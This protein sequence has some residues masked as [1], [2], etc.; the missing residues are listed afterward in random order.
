MTTIIT[1]PHPLAPLSGD[2][3]TAARQIVFES[4]KAGIP[5]EDIR[6]AY[7]GLSDP[8]KE[9]VRAVDRGETV[10]V[11]RRLRL[12]LLLGPVANVT[13]VIVSV[14]R[15]VV[16]SWVEVE[17]VR[18]A[19]QMEEAI[20]I[21][22]AL[23]ENPDWNA[24]LDRRGITDRSLVQIDPWPAGTFGTEHEQGRRIT[25]C[26][27][28]LRH[29]PDDNG[30]ARPLEGLMAYVDMGRGTVLEVVDLGVVPLPP[31]LGSYYPEDNGPL[32]TDLRPLAIT[33]PEGPSFTVDGNLVR[34]QKWS[35]RVGMDPLEGLVLH[36]VGYEDGGRVRPLLFRASVSEMVVPYGHPGPMHSWK[37][38]FDAG[39]WG[40]G[41]MANSLTLGCDCLGEIFYFD[42][43]YSD[44][45][46][47]PRTRPNAICMHEEDYGILWK[48]LDMTSGRTEVRRSRR[49]VVSSIATVGN[50]EYGFYW[51]FYQDGS[52]QLEVKLSGI[53]STMSVGDDGPGAHASMIAPGLAAP[54]HQHLFNVRLDVE[55]D[56]PD[57]AVFEVDTVPSPP[58]ED[59]PWGNAFAPEATLLESELAAR[60]RVDPSRS[61]VWKIANRAV[62]NGVGQPTAYKLLP[63]ATPTLLADPAS[64]VGRRATFAAH[65]LWVTPFD[66]DE[67]RAAGDYPNQ[68]AGGA[69]LPEWT[70][71]DRPVVDTDIV[72]WHSFGVTHIPRPEDWPVMP[73]E[74]TGFSLIPV[75]FFD[76]NPALDVAPTNGGDAGGEGHCHAT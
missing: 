36:T 47:K 74:Y 34:W 37:S 44:E 14:T 57:N 58:G 51:Y 65:N 6:F 15:R 52:M 17:D 30:Y 62:V 7:V 59:N 10:E 11:D 68:H 60:R 71:Q 76:R 70:A 22:A 16:D 72:L 54:F 50:Y 38:A 32:R 9:M 26:L 13:E 8:P 40:L 64:S 56:G 61:R 35:L 39:E 63:A 2:E 28:Y 31:Q 43:I 21:L 5:D 1:T 66:P 19:L 67:R 41:R 53:M 69:G 29:S 20:G 12:Q 45:R 48:H 75:G 49:L 23:Y 42:D 24:A 27:A 25:R 73:V 46:G 18:P 3:I 4:G 55:I 33:Q